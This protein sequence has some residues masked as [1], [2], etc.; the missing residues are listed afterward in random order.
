M[1]ASALDFHIANIEQINRSSSLTIRNP[2]AINI[3]RYSTN[4]DFNT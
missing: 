4:K 1:G 3:K 2:P